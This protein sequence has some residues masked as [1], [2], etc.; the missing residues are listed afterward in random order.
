MVVLNLE[1]RLLNY[2]IF[3]FTDSLR[4][5]GVLLNLNFKEV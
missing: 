1:R 4:I 2:A 5:A 3:G